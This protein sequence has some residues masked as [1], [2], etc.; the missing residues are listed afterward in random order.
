MTEGQDNSVDFGNLRSAVHTSH[1]PDEKGLDPLFEALTLPQTSCLWN[2]FPH[3]DYVYR[4]V[5]W[6]R[7]CKALRWTYQKRDDQQT[8][9]E[10]QTRQQTHSDSFGTWFGY[11]EYVLMVEPMKHRHTD[12]DG[13]LALR[14]GS[15]VLEVTSPLGLYHK[16]IDH[17]F[18]RAEWEFSLRLYTEGKT[19]SKEFVGLVGEIRRAFFKMYRSTLHGDRHFYVNVAHMRHRLEMLRDFAQDRF[20]NYA[21][22][23]FFLLD[24]CKEALDC[25][26]GD[27]RPHL[28]RPTI[29]NELEAVTGIHTMAHK[30]VRELLLKQ[31]FKSK[32][33][34]LCRDT[35]RKA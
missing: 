19:D 12:P 31:D 5:P 13:Y 16:W 6:E 34:T 24:A 20:S 25:I 26:D 4:S 17:L 9:D 7:L 27:P 23:T 33:Y 32:G 14:L 18:A 8:R 3:W 35:L 28:K 2:T 1:D 21:R 30:G 29:R 10:Q 11:V 22:A 15:Y